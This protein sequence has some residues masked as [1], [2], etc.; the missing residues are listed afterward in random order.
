MFKILAGLV[1]GLLGGLTF[2]N[3]IP[4]NFHET[5]TTAEGQQQEI[6]YTAYFILDYFDEKSGVLCRTFVTF[7][8]E[9]LPALEK[10]DYKKHARQLFKNGELVYA[11]AETY[12]YNWSNQSA[13]VQP[14][15]FTWKGVIDESPFRINDYHITVAPQSQAI[16]PPLVKYAFYLTKEFDIDSLLKIN[17]QEHHMQGKAKRMTREELARMINSAK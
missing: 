16:T 7:G 11:V 13:T 1:S 6:H 17:G 5:I 15:S 4:V 12:F 9:R 3:N 8:D 10:K 14:V 2:A